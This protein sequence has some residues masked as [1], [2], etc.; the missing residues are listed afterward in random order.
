MK[1][2]YIGPW[3]ICNF[4][5]FKLILVIDGWGVFCEIALRWMPLDLTDT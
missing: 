3:E 5:I 1:I 4:L 2:E